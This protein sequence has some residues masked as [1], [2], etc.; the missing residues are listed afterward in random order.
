[1]TKY[2]RFESSLPAAELLPG[3]W[4]KLRGG[5]NL[6][7][8]YWLY[9]RTGEA[10]LLDLARRLYERTADWETAIINPDRDRSWEPSGFYHG[11]NIAMGFRYPGVYFQ[12]SG[13]EKHLEI[14]EKNYRFVMDAYGQA[15]G[16]NVRSR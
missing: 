8:V 15:A 3:S 16:R 10:W 7:S 5:E 4:Q 12:Q 6:E 14:V 11:V 13:D 1:M 2:F 9:N